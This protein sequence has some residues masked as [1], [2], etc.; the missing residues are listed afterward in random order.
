MSEEK[1][2][3]HT[4]NAVHLVAS[5]EK[6]WRKKI[7][8][9]IEEV[10]III[11]A[12]SVTL[13]L[14]NWNDWRNERK[15]EKEFLTGIKGDL[16]NEV[17]HLN[18]SVTRLN[19]AAHYY[20]TVWQQINNNKVNAS[21]V[22][23]NSSE[24]VTTDYF[25]FDNGRFESFKSSGYLRIISN[26]KL[27]K[28]ISSLYTVYF[29]FEVF[30]DNKIYSMRTTGY[31]NYI[32]AKAFVDSNGMTHISPLLNDPA[33]RHQIFFYKWYIHERIN[34]KKALAAKITKVIT[35]IEHEINK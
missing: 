18:N 7:V 19:F 32:G 23:R 28:D 27:L 11:F 4:Q 5:K 8:E 12:V 1:I 35:E 33:V 16:G 26:Q 6:T 13:A 9:L 21:Y 29:P 17:K 30:A 24:L 3:K 20:D 2:I 15:M 25:A 31:E 22:D 14:H 34:Q 10:A